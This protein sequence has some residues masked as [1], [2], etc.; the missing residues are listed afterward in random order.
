MKQERHRSEVVAIKSGNYVI[1]YELH[2]CRE[3]PPQPERNRNPE[4][5][6]PQT[7]A[8]RLHN[9]KMCKRKAARTVNS[10]FQSDDYKLVLSFANE[11]SGFDEANDCV[12]LFLRR[13]NRILAKTGEKLCY[14][15]VISDKDPETKEEERIHVHMIVKRTPSI[16]YTKIKRG[17][18]PTFTIGE[19]DIEDLW[20]NGIVR[21]Q[22][23][24][25]RDQTDVVRYMI[26]QSA[27]PSGKAKYKF[28]RGM[29]IPK[30]TIYSG[31]SLSVTRSIHPV[32]E[33]DIVEW[34][35]NY[36]RLVLKGPGKDCAGQVCLEFRENSKPNF[37]YAC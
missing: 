5:R 25:G 22:L 32:E 26:N 14:F 8:Q 9:I 36:Q 15:L 6:N 37:H 13:V 29:A 33:V 28:A 21:V 24:T 20:G 10:N 3:A 12:K 30:R 16:H 4:K 7:E 11:P 35:C 31:A 1:E 19:K 2:T 17:K 27:A 34:G 23:L 18:S